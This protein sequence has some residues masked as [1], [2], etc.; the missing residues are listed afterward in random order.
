MT[1]FRVRWAACPTSQNPTR[2]N[3]VEADDEATAKALLTDHVQRTHHHAHIVI[4]AAEPYTKPTGG[5]VLA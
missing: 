3:F 4:F 2:V 5:R 1:E